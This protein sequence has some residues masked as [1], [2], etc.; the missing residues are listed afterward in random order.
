MWNCFWLDLAGL[1][2]VKYHW[3]L[4]QLLIHYL[5]TAQDTA[6]DSWKTERE[7]LVS[8]KAVS[9]ADIG[10]LRGLYETKSQGPE[11]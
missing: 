9:D 3:Q 4:R 8:I 2:T 11:D 1:E 10:C 7:S 5:G 6:D